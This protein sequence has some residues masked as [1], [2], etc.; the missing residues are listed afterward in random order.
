MNAFHVK[1]E[2]AIISK[3]G[4]SAFFKERYTVDFISL[5]LVLSLC[6]CLESKQMLHFL[7][8]QPYL[9]QL[10]CLQ[11]HCRC[12]ILARL[13]ELTDEKKQSRSHS[14][15]CE[16]WC[17]LPVLSLSIGGKWDWQ[18]RHFCAY[19]A[20]LVFLWSEKIRSERTAQTLPTNWAIHFHISPL[21][22][23]CLYFSMHPCN[24]N[25]PNLHRN[26]F[27]TTQFSKKILTS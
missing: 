6:F 8:G 12:I 27:K 14:V 18:S 7:R 17:G 11:H 20:S 16:G 23:S 13:R 25:I 24:L 10:K 22:T 15:E 19:R 3:A 5:L 21:F 2:K 9:S 1:I 26:E 4:T